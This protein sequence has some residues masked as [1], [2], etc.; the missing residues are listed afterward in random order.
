[1]LAVAAV[2]SPYT[3]HFTPFASTTKQVAL[4]AARHAPLV[5]KVS[6]F[7]LPYFKAGSALFFTGFGAKE[8]AWD[9]RQLVIEHAHM[10]DSNHKVV[11][12]LG[13]PLVHGAFLITSGVCSAFEALHAFALTN[14]GNRLPTIVAAGNLSFLFANVL[15]LEENVNLYEQAMALGD[16]ATEEEHQLAETMKKSAVL[17]IMSNLGYVASTATALLGLSSGVALLLAGFGSCWG[18]LKI[19]Y[20]FYLAYL[21]N[22]HFKVDRALM[23]QPT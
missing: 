12:S 10:K 21:D 2:S 13:Y 11:S 8:I 7:V 4:F 9:H 14:L 1:M 15:A 6:D 18:G 23:H 19:L 3:S 16:G 20:D 5:E 22:P 17:G